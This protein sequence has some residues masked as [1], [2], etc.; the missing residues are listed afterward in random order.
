MIFKK[1]FTKQK[2]S[3]NLELSP[4]LTAM[5][6]RIKKLGEKIASDIM[7][8]RVDTSTIHIGQPIHEVIE[9]IKDEGYSRLPVWKDNLDNIVGVLYVKDLF[10]RLEAENSSLI[11]KE[12]IISEKFLRDPFL[13]PESKKVESLLKEFQSNKVHLAVVL[14]EYGGFSGIITLEDILEIITGD[15]QDEYDSETADIRKISDTLYELDSRT[16]LEEVEEALGISYTAYKEEIDTVGGLI[17]N[18]LERVPRIGEEILIDGIR[19]KI[20]KKEGN[21]ILS[22]KVEIPPQ[23]KE[24]EE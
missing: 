21:K 13:I 3:E 16:G 14:D 12:G 9:M 20:T 6:T 23:T 24:D 2:K 5:T 10:Y 17:Y 7:I 1:L 4:F 11:F 15:I 8:P 18:N 19:Y 22:L